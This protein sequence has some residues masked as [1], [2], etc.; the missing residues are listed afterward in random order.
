VLD[1]RLMFQS[2]RVGRPDGPDVVRSHGD[3]VSELGLALACELRGRIRRLDY[4]PAA[5][6][7]M[8]G[9]AAVFADDADGADGPNIIRRDRGQAFDAPVDESR[10]R[11][12]A[13]ARMAT[14]LPA[15]G[16]RGNVQREE[17]CDCKPRRRWRGILADRSTGFH[18]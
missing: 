15:R 3:D 6:I 10:A 17:N 5:A 1:Q 16:D 2:F 14:S 13:P 12:I 9:Q 7:P 8:F 18:F 4:T 11:H